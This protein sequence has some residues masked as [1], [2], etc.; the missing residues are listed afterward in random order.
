LSKYE[1]QNK[2]K[3]KQNNKEFINCMV[4]ESEEGKQ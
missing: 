3:T 4:A 1:K 2:E